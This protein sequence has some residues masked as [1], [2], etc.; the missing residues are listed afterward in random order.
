VLAFV[1]SSV[2]VYRHDRDDPAKQARAQELLELLW[3]RR[4]GRLSVQ[5]LSD[6]YVV[7]TRKLASPLAR[8][9]ARAE[10]RQ[11]EAWGPVALSAPVRE[12]AWLLEERFHLSWWDA[13]IVAAAAETGCGLLLTEDLQD[14]QV[15]DGVKV[16]NPFA[17]DL[18]ELDL[19]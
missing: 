3:T 1:D 10:A 18:A 6:F 15:F 13:L 5:V 2:L 19:T 17:H 11:L 8:E 9:L 7:S 4:C 16:M 12:R 14:G